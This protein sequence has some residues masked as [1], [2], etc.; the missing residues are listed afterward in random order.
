MSTDKKPLE[1]GCKSIAYILTEM[2][3]S[4]GGPSLP[5]VSASIDYDAMLKGIAGEN[6]SNLVDIFEKYN[7]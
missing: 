6:T 4:R 1:E 3:F 2:T 5:G 7:L